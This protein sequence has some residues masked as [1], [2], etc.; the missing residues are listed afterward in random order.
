M[1][2]PTPGPIPIPWSQRWRD[3]RLHYFPALIFIAIL[4]LLVLLWK[5]YASAPTLTGQA[6]VVPANISSYKPG[7]LAQLNVN[8]FQKVKAGDTVGQVLV[9][10]PKILASSLAVIQA[11][12]Q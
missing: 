5:N 3:V 10:D 8:R 9:T 6:E 1:T 2:P 7:M 11:E 12:I 4:V